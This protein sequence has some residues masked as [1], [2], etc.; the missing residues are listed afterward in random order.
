MIGPW[1]RRRDP[2]GLL[3]LGLLAIGAGALFRRG[4]LLLGHANGEAETHLWVQHMLRRGLLEG[5]SM[6]V[7]DDL[8]SGALV[9]LYPTDLLVRLPA[10]LLGGLVGDEAAYNL[11][12][13]AQIGL[14]VWATVALARELGA[15]RWSSLLAGAVVLLHPGQLGFLACGQ[16]DSLALGWLVLVVLMWVR[17]VRAP[18][19][20]RGIKLGLVAGLL[21]GNSLNLAFLGAWLLSLASLVVLIRHPRRFFLPLATAAAVG[22]A[23]GGC[24]ASLMLWVEQGQDRLRGA[25]DQ[26]VLEWV[27][28]AQ[29]KRDPNHSAREVSRLLQRE[30]ISGRWYEVPGLVQDRLGISPP[31]FTI[32]ATPWISGG[33]FY[34]AKVPLLLLL[35]GCVLTPRRLLPCLV[36]VLGLQL[37]AFG[38]GLPHAAPLALPGRSELLVVRTYELITMLPGGDLFR[39]FSLFNAIGAA[40]LGV[41][42]SLVPLGLSRRRRPWLLGAALL[43]WVVEVQLLGNTPLPIVTQEMTVPAGMQAALRRGRSAVTLLPENGNLAGFLFRFHGRRSAVIWRGQGVDR[44]QGEVPHPTILHHSE[45]DIGRLL[46]W[47]HSDTVV[48][49]P[50]LWPREVARKARAQLGSLCGPPVWADPGGRVMVFV[51]G[52]HRGPRAR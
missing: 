7:H 20:R 39:N 24:F 49:F 48:F 26:L 17:L 29:V 12:A 2:V 44:P 3:W 5:R 13:L 6:F 51:R 33:W 1:L 11:F 47:G 23:L 34:L 15:T 45:L 18:S 21:V 41:A 16:A 36:P 27:T 8:L 28:P 46:A 40:A 9:K 32:G 35:I 4:P 52:G 42:V 25:P 50:H 38:Y 14:A 10:A 22:L 43:L 31:K 19:W 30:R 37:L